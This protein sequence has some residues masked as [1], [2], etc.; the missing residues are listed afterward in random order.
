MR[1]TLGTLWA[2]LILTRPGLSQSAPRALVMRGSRH[3][4][5]GMATAE[6]AVG[7]LAAAA[8]AGLLLAL[9]RSGSLTGALQALIE[10]ALSVG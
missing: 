1:R 2:C 10:S 7:T 6:Y 3:G 8:F 9:I 5:E 4:E